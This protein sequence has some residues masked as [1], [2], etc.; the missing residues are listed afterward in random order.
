MPPAISAAFH[1]PVPRSVSSTKRQ[2]G[3]SAMPAGTDTTDRT[4]GIRRPTTISTPPRSSNQWS[5]RS[6]SAGLIRSSQWN[7]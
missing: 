5:A 2:I 6:R 1:T 4:S 7:R 3:I